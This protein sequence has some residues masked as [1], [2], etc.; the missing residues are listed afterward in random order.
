[1][2]AEYGIKRLKGMIQFM[3]SEDWSLRMP[4]FV[5][6]INKMD[7]IR[8]TS[9]RAVFPEMIELMDGNYE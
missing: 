2:E 4:E 6:Y 1:M 7:K 9:F 5:E 3:N 8:Q